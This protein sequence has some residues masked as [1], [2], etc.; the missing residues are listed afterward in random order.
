MI[1]TYADVVQHMNRLDVNDV[2][3]ALD[4][5]SEDITDRFSDWIEDDLQRLIEWY[6]LDE[7]NDD[8]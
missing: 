6:G 1:P 8:V 4:L 3:E 5:V 7:E 2:V